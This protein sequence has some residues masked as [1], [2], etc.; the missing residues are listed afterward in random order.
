MTAAAD[1]RLSTAG[2]LPV[3]RDGG[4]RPHERLT[5]GGTPGGCQRTC[6]R[7][8]RAARRARSS[9]QSR[10]R[11]LAI[12]GA[13]RAALRLTCPKGTMRFDPIRLPMSE[14]LENHRRRRLRH[15]ALAPERPP[16]D[17]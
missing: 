13:W 16:H 12:P 4:S 10:E 2:L 1:V 8:R 11:A 7:A 3:V 5:L 9:G 6:T 17:S 14:I 15:E